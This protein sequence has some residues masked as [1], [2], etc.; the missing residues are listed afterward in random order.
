MQ[1][2][3]CTPQMAGWNRGRGVR[4]LTYAYYGEGGCTAEHPQAVE[5]NPQSFTG[6][7]LMPLVGIARKA[8]KLV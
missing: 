4:N 7:S 3:T 2:H 1:R 5:F 8:T 6:T